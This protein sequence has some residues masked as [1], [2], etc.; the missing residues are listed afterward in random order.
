[1]K[2]RKKLVIISHTAHYKSEDGTIVGWGATVNEVN[3]MA[4]H[5]EEVV[6]I[7]CLHK[8]PP[9]ASSSPYTKSNIRFV[10]IP[11]YGGKGL[12]SKLLIFNKKP[13]IISRVLKNIK[14]ATEVQLRLPTAMGLFLLPLFSFFVKRKFSFWVKYAG[15]WGQDNPPFSYA[16]QRRMLKLQKCPVTIN[17]HWP[18]QPEHCHSFENPCL[19]EEDITNGKSISE[20][21][22]FQSPFV[23]TFIGR[24]D[25]AKGVS[26]LLEALKYIPSEKIKSV[27]FA[28]D[29]KDIETY[30]TTAAFLGDKVNFHGFVTQQEVHAILKESHFLLLP[31][32]SEGFPK[33]IAEAAC[34]G[35]IP[36]VSTVG[37]ISHYINQ[38]NGFLWNRETGA[39]YDQLL[40]KAVHSS[41]EELKHIS[42]KATLL[43]ADFTFNN[44]LQKLKATV[45]KGNT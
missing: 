41:P 45:F 39:T 4:G 7:G 40:D 26:T 42:Q 16:L 35:A 10:A 29:G 38:S 12:L 32:K 3:F 15:N 21:K 9:P 36:I 20:N 43:A 31:S 37:S 11:P 23:F 33:V 19:T 27:H 25:E 13:Q 34:Y 44:Y 8:T 2:P 1:M 30:K 14:G 17:G 28:G 5:W 18:N 24:L 6:H 22:E